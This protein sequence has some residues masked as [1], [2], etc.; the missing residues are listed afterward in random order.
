MPRSA[1]S[2]PAATSACSPRAAPA[3]APRRARFFFSRIP[4]QPPALHLSQAGRR[5]HGRDHHGRRRRHLAAGRYRI[6]TERTRFAMPET[7][8]GLFPDVGGGWYLSRLPGASGIF[9]ALTGARLDGAECLRARPRHRLS[10]RPRALDD[11]QGADRR[12]RRSGSR[13]SLDEFARRRRPR[14][15]RGSI[16]TRSTACS[17]PTM[18]EE[19][20]AALEADGGDWAQKRAGDAAHQDRRWPEG[21]AARA[22]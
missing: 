3:T 7:G 5:G 1:A 6:A 14:A 9:L 12:R 4:A 18:L 17:P 15:D 2:A 21:L 8:I 11:A 13:R 19:I 16:A 10:S 20:L 22:R